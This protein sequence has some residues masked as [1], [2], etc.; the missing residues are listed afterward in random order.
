LKAGGAYVPIDPAYPAERIAYI[1]GHSQIPVLLTQVHLLPTLP[2][3]QANVICLDRDWAT[4]A[5]ESEENPD[6]LATSDNLIYVIYT[7]GS[8][9]NPKGVALE[10]RSVIYFLSWAHDTYT[11]EEM[12]GV[13]FSTSICF[14]LS[15][16][17]MFATLTMGGKVIMAENALQLP[18]LPAADQ[19]TLVNTVPSAATEL[20]RMKGIPA[21]VRVI[22]LCGEPLSN[23][24][25]QELYAFPYVEK[26]F[27]LYGPTEDTVYSTHA[28]VTKGATN[29][30]LIGRPQFN[31]HVFVLDSHRKP[32]PVGVPGELYLSGS[33]LARGYL[34]RPDLTAER[35]VQNPFREPGARMYRTGDLVRY[36]PDG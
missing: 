13:L 36:L 21:S 11:P 22:N 24:L 3:H 14:D 23:R 1:I 16:Y 7:S 8:T 12:S 25:A 20:V 19:V 2:E 29:E 28:I 18:A 6:K 35:F 30:P 33:G 34:H 4:V 9:G 15:V 10:H 27:N 31:T 17:E 32:V 26:V 5:V